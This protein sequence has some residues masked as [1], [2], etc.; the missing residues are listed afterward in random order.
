MRPPTWI[1]RLLGIR[2]LA[3]GLVEIVAPRRLTFGVCAGIDATHAVSMLAAARI[4][5]TYR[6]A[7]LLSA[8]AAGLS[9]VVGVAA[10]ASLEPS[11]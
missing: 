4:W 5:P 7:A 1:L 9:A 6:R 3:Q 8:A 2:M 11:P 10:A